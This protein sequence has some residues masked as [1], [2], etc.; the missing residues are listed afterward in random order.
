MN[1]DGILRSLERNKP[2]EDEGPDVRGK[3][4]NVVNIGKLNTLIV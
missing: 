1:E 4:R 3:E 2:T